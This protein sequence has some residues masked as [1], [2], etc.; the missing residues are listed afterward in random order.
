MILRQSDPTVHEAVMLW[1]TGE[2]TLDEAAYAAAC[3]LAHKNRALLDEL[4]R[5][6]RNQPVIFV[7]D[8]ETVEEFVR[9]LEQGG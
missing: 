6:L 8:G 1:E 7:T 9:R 5:I 3:S 4:L 2:C